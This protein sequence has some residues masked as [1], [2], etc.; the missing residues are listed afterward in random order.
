MRVL[1]ADDDL[2]IRALL[3]DMLADLGH[4]VTAAANGAEA[5]DLAARD[6]PDLI[7]LD[8]LMPRLSGLDAMKAMR[9]RGLSMPIVLLTA[10]SDASMRELEGVDRADAVMEKPFKKRTL[11]KAIA[12]AM[13]IDT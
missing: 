12:K 4:D 5:V 8:F 2:T 10:I 13:R 3:G 11:E 1:I 9:Q 7:I 6:Q